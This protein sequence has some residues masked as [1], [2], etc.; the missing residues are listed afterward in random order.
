MPRYFLL[1][2]LLCLAATHL[3]SALGAS[4]SL[5]EP[6]SRAVFQRNADNLATI[7][8]A[9]TYSGNVTSIE[10][11][12]IVMDGFTGISTEWQVVE[13]GPTGETFRSQ[14]AVPA[15][16]WYRIETRVL[17]GGQAVGQSSVERVGVGEVFVTAGQ[18]N[19]ANHGS[20]G[21]SIDNPQQPTDDRV[22]AFNGIEWR[23][24]NDPQPV[25]TGT[26][27]SP[28]P[29]LGDLVSATYQV[30]VGF[31]SV[32][33]GGTTV[34]D[35]VPGAAGPDATPL[36]NRLQAALQSLGP[37]GVRAVLW[38]QGESDNALN[39]STTDYAAQLESVIAQSR[40]DAGFDVPWGVALASYIDRFDPLD[41]QIV[42]G[43]L[44][45]IA[46]DPLVFAGPN[47]D[48]MVIPY[49]NG[50]NFT[51]IH[52]NDEGLREH[53]RRWFQELQAN[54]LLVPEPTSLCIVVLGLSWLLPVRCRR[55]QRR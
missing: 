3:A 25:A 50:V 48:T 41:Q 38:H 14:L 51:G 20:D 28:W 22:S 44:Q 13:S 40:I 36:Y 37:A 1:P 10:A 11:R 24:A 5:T 54:Q 32:G 49:R 29:A 35:W 27:G 55:Q 23:I 2:T 12:A 31:Y 16:G 19:S 15:G 45:V 18:S 39:T 17:D 53:A 42:D 21:L 7:P 43:Q 46:N 26:G 34:G 33:W 30:P 9:G 47:T 4:V 8:I 6:L 52:F